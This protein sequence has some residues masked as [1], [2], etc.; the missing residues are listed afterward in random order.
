MAEPDEL[1]GMALYL[2]SSASDFVT[3][4]AF[5]ADGGLLVGSGMLG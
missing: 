1:A 4:S 3:G 5:R 2:G